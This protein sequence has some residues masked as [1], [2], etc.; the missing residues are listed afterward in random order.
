M[1]WLFP[2]STGKLTTNI[3]SAKTTYIL[4]ARATKSDSN[5]LNIINIYIGILRRSFE[6]NFFHPARIRDIELLLKKSEK[7]RPQLA[8]SSSNISLQSK[9]GKD[10]VLIS[11]INSQTD[12]VCCSFNN[13]FIQSS[14][15]LFILKTSLFPR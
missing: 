9:S 14:S 1:A 3:N 5:I 15:S 6:L 13:L 8:P 7:T 12:L 2:N 11:S 4:S 10:Y